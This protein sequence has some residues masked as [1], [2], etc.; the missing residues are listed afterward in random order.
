MKEKISNNPELSDILNMGKASIAPLT[1]YVDDS[2]ITTLAHNQ[3]TNM[4]IVE[5]AFSMAQEWLTTHSMKVDQGK[6]ELIHFTQSNCGRHSGEGPAITVPTNNPRELKTIQPVKVI[7]YLGIWLDSHLNFTAHVQKTT[8]KAITTA[9]ALCLLS[10]SIRGMHQTNAR[11]LYQ[12]AIL[13]IATYGF[14]SF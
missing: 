12:G 6:S 2:S 10:N 8:S 5:A 1:L 4:K 13:P 3:I 14:P 9:H 7:R 11:Q